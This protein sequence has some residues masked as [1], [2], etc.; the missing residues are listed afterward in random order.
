MPP[1]FFIEKTFFPD[2][3]LQIENSGFVKKC[4][5]YVLDLFTG[6]FN[7]FLSGHENKHVPGISRQMNLDGLIY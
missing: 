1:L 3:Q 5:E 2:K 6:D 7:V 4:D